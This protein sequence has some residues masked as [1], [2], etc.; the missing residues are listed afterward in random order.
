MQILNIKRLLLLLVVFILSQHLSYSQLNQPPGVETYTIR[1][2]SVM[3]PLTIVYLNNSEKTRSI[4]YVDGFGR[5]IQNTLVA[6]SPEGK[7]II[8]FSKYDQYGR[9]P[10]QYLPFEASSGTGAYYDMSTITIVQSNFYT[11]GVA[12]SK[13]VAFDNY[14]YGE[15]SFEPSPL[16]RVLKTGGIGDGFQL[17]QHYKTINYRNN[18]VADNVQQW[19]LGSSAASSTFNYAADELTVSEVVDENNASS[20]VF[21]DKLGRLVL[22]R[23]HGNYDTYYVYDNTGN[24][25][26]IVPPKAIVKMAGTYNTALTPELI[27]QF[28][29]DGKNRIVRKKVPGATEVYMVYDPLDRVVLTQDGNM[30]SGTTK[31]LAYVKYDNANRVI[32][33]GIYNNNN[34]LEHMQMD[35]ND[36]S[37]YATNSTTYYEIREAGTSGYSNQ[38]F[39]TTDTEER[40]YNYF[41]NYDFDFD[42]TADY[43]KDQSLTNEA[44]ATDLTYGLATGSKRK[45]LGSGTP[46]TWL[47]D[48]SFYDKYYHVIQ[49]RSNNQQK[50]DV[51]DH[52]TNVVNFAGQAVQ[53]KQVKTINNPADRNN[54][55]VL[56]V[57]TRYE[58]DDMGRLLKVRQSN[59]GAAELIVAKY[60]YNPLGQLVDKKLHSTDN[61]VNYLQSVDMRYNIRGQ[62]ISINNS[63]RNI[64][65]SNNDEAN[66]VFGMEILY[67]KDESTG[68]GNTKNYTGMVSAIKWSA[69]GPASNTAQRSFKYSY[70]NM[71]RLTAATYQE[72]GTS[73]WD[74]RSGDFDESFS[75]DENGNILTTE[76]WAKL[77]GSK[78]KIDQL[79]Y[80]YKSSGFNN[81]LENISDAITNN[82]TGYG[83]RNFTNTGNSTPYSYDDNGNLSTDLKKGT[84]I[85]YNELNKP[86][87][88]QI[89]STK[90]CE[91][92]YDAA[93]TRISKIV[94]NNSTVKT[95]EYIGGYVI[96]NDILSYYS[97]AEGRVRNDG[98][99]A[100]YNVVPVMEYFITDQ[101]GNTRVSFED[102]GT[103]TVKLTQ[104][105]SYYAFGMQMTGG[106][107]PT[108]NPNKKLYNAGS[109]W[110]DDVEGMADYY[111]TFIREYDPVI[112][113]FNGVDPMSESFE[114]WTTY[115]YSYNNPVNFN[116]PMGNK[117]E[118]TLSAQMLK[119]YQEWHNPQ[120]GNGYFYGSWD[121]DGGGGGGG[122]ISQSD[123]LST[124]AGLRMRVNDFRSNVQHGFNNFGE[125]GSWTTH[126]I[127]GEPNYNSED[128]VIYVPTKK[129]RV[130]VSVSTPDQ[131]SAKSESV[132]KPGTW[133]SII[134]IWGSGRAAIDDYQN[135][136]IWSGI[137]NTLLAISDVFLVKSIIT[138]V[139]KLAAV[140][141]SKL[142]A[143]EGVTI[144]GEGMARVE[145]TA[146]KIPGATIMN[147]MPVFTGTAEQITSKMMQ[148][149]R[150]WILNEIRS[151][152]TILDIGRDA[153]R[154]NPSIFYQME[155][156]MIKN[157]KLLHPQ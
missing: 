92:R 39:P 73:A 123:F 142:A 103:N 91:Y 31:K 139:G 19:V 78:T 99:Q 37:C 6:G 57:G 85:T 95:I 48:I 49:V 2:E 8:S 134:P 61:G 63:A 40:G 117:A 23:Q 156:N 145:A 15:S 137:G 58:Y 18:R 110:Q 29:Y 12:G 24:I 42:G 102:D 107:A 100:G 4:S 129:E 130:W 140:G 89:S 83:Y 26:F 16:G 69:A 67:D 118:P 52:T 131:A 51:T 5:P 81:Q 64:N 59:L 10:K 72:K 35:V 111:S 82:T 148:Y 75:Y 88:I 60:E 114:S 108:V 146:A 109:E 143:K 135:G 113:R 97:M 74:Q 54:T 22:K 53:A 125:F 32:I 13:K 104:E 7:D 133:E 71:Y 65:T 94:T 20:L 90:K 1:K 11:S 112:G 14:P 127:F 3:D 55:R 121:W 34:S 84:T 155:Q 154:V 149:N 36:E 96:E 115:N 80:S 86:T 101:Q 157:Y 56:E 126:F 87:L 44:A 128:G 136:H 41:D 132:G 28:W 21:N 30:R 106:Y 119:E 124:Y 43:S 138:G 141:I 122:G 153:T 50:T 45:I 68:L 17:N 116:D 70:D 105:N 151:G 120:Y 79:T 27:Y 93:G 38:C 66:D 47:V 62:L 147:T 77:A 98:D 33:Q 9:Q 144:I 152:Q 76:R 150:Q 46:G 25:A